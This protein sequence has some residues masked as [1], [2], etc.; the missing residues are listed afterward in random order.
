MS[1]TIATHPVQVHDRLMYRDEGGFAVPQVVSLKAYEV[2]CEVYGPQGAL[3]TGNCRG[4][5]GSGE[6]GSVPIR[7]HFSTQ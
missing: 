1:E 7:S 6:F 4:G 3:I 2:Y 5:F